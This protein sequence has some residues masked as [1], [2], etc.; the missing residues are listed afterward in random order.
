MLPASAPSWAY[1]V[2]SVCC[3]VQEREADLR[4]FVEVATRQVWTAHT[5]HGISDTCLLCV[6]VRVYVCVFVC[7]C[8]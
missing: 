2:R 6:C 1:T 7:L 4:L 3:A 5:W 8:V